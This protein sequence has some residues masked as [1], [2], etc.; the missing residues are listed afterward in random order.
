MIYQIS[1]SQPQLPAPPWAITIQANLPSSEHPA[2]VLKTVLDGLGI[3]DSFEHI[4][5]LTIARETDFVEPGQVRV[6][7]EHT[8]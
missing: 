2:E 4:W 3:N 7:I 5:Y 8:I 6:E 1:T